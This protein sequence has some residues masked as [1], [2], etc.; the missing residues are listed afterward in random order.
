MKINFVFLLC[1][2]D[3]GDIVKNIFIGGVAKSGKSRL[4]VNLCKKYGMS[5]IPLDYFTSSF[6]HIFPELGISSDVIINKKTSELLSSYLAR[7]IEIIELRDDE[8]FV[9][10]TAHV[11]PEDI[12]KYLDRDK[13]NIYYLAYPNAIVKNKISEINKY[14]SGG[15]TS[16]KNNNELES[17]FKKLIEISKNIEDQCKSADIDFIDTSNEDIIDVFEGK[18]NQ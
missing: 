18:F 12:V 8:F 10:D 17:T 4:A 15:W 6:K 11:F 5:H 14:I 9:L 1:Y 13:W 16:S 2:T 7:V 3:V